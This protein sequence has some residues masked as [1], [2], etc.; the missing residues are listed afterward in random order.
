[1]TQND[2]AERIHPLKAWRLTQRHWDHGRREFRSVSIVEASR[3]FGVPPN[4]WTGW[5]RYADEPGAR[6][7]DRENMRKLF[8]FTRGQVRPDHFYD[9]P[10][11]RGAI[12]AAKEAGLIEA[13]A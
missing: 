3:D 12:S 6:V 1:M 5:E 8:L 13:Q 4:T 2:T 7:P 9:L 10:E 11:L